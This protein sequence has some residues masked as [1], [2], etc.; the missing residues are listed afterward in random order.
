MI[1]K[2]IHQIWIQG[3]DKI[4]V[5]FNENIQK[6]K[7][8]NPTWKYIIWDETSIINLLNNIPEFIE[9]YNSFQYL[10]QKADF[11]RYIILYL[12]GGVYIDIDATTVKSL[13][14]FIDR[15]PTYDF[16]VSKNRINIFESYLVCRKKE[17]INNGIIFCKKRN[18]I[19]KQIINYILSNSYE[20]GILTPKVVCI[21]ETTGPKMFTF[22][23]NKNKKDTKMKIVEAEYLEPCIKQTCI[24]TD[25]TYIIHKHEGSWI[26]GFLQLIIDI[27]LF[28]KSNIV[29]IFFTITIALYFFKYSQ[30]KP[31]YYV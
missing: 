22:I 6:I 14:M 26:N 31:N 17:C 4:P 9:K 13:D 15:F 24:I 25:N 27:Y 29:S 5:K 19:M 2:I 20:C 3:Y 28:S 23:V 18:Q 1:E 16:I 7:K 8:L 10:H 12:F 11:A 21:T 30:I